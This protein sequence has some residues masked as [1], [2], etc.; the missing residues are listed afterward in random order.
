[1]KKEEEKSG[2]LHDNS[3]FLFCWL[4]PH[5]SP[6][7]LE[8]FLTGIFFFFFPKAK[9]NGDPLPSVKKRNPR[10]A[11]LD[12]LHLEMSG[13][14]SDEESA[15]AAPGVVLENYTKVPNSGSKCVVCGAH[16]EKGFT[17]VPF[18]AQVELAVDYFPLT[19][20]TAAFA[21]PIWREAI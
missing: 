19:T 17:R 21:F 1:M 8:N 4:K 9:E 13:E 5:L 15:P 2:I 20:P 3:I 12:P 7:D 10:L 6:H 14:S 11:K 16:V 18:Y